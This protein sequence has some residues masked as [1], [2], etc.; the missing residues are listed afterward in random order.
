LIR[1]DQ[2]ASVMREGRVALPHGRGRVCEREGA[3]ALR[4]DA[5]NQTGEQLANCR[6]L[7]VV[8]AAHLGH[9]QH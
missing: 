5:G 3:A 2:R 9:D 7:R 4:Y 6:G 1:V 8:L